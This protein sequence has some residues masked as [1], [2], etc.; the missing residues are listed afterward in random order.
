[1]TVG[2]DSNVGRP[3]PLLPRPIKASRKAK[4]KAA[5]LAPA[6]RKRKSKSK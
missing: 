4:P 6:M 1:M 3:L 2:T 5:P